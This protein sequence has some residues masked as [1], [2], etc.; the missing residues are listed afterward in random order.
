MMIRATCHRDRRT[1][2][3]AARRAYTFTEF[4]VALIVF[5]IA[6]SGMLPM[7]AILSRHLQPLPNGASSP[8]RDWSNPA[9]PVVS[10]RP[11]AWSLMACNDPC[12]AL[13]LRKLGASA[14]ASSG[15]VTF[16]SLPPIQ[17][18]VVFLDDCG[19]YSPAG[20]YGTPSFSVG[21]GWGGTVSAAL[22]LNAEQY[23]KAAL[24][25]GSTSTGPALWTIAVSAGGWY[26]IQAT[27]AAAPDQVTDAQFTAQKTTNGSTSALG[28]ATVN[29][30]AAP[31]GIADSNG[32]F[33]APLTSL[34]QLAANDIVQVQLSDVRATSKDPGTYYVA[35]DAVRLVR[36]D[37]AIN[38][39][40]RSFGCTKPDGTAR[41]D[42]TANVSVT[43]N[44]PQ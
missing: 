12:N 36:N 37:V 17:P 27:W 31:A 13:W 16:S 21:S 4:L 15:T 29:Q 10:N 25:A 24:P 1:R 26:S 19:Q 22:A 32:R 34:V 20:V 18:A 7:V 6:L 44:I 43:V 41:P 5:G 2:P 30:Q 11:T 35:A 8:A 14:Q 39:I 33:W 42:V 38:S 23:R 9:C 3:A 40:M 28:A